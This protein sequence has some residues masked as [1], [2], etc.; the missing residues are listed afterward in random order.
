MAN[1]NPAV[2]NPQINLSSA[3]ARSGR[4]Y[5]SVR[6]FRNEREYFGEAI[7][8]CEAILQK[9]GFHAIANTQLM[10]HLTAY[11]LSLLKSEKD[12]EADEYLERATSVRDLLLGKLPQNKAQLKLFAE[13]N[14]SIAPWRGRTDP[15]RAIEDYQIAINTFEELQARNPNNSHYSKRIASTKR[16]QAVAFINDGQI[17]EAKKRFVATMK[18]FEELNSRPARNMD[19]LFEYAT[20]AQNLAAFHFHQ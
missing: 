19:T 7:S 12:E 10:G 20:S 4:A 18:I 2:I 11:A 16:N 1:A 8:I 3:L 14:V 5:A 17:E 13:S 6:K 15:K 9:H